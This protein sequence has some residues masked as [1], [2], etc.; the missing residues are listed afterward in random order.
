MSKSKP[1]VQLVTAGPE[2]CPLCAG[3]KVH[4]SA[5]DLY[6]EAHLCD[7]IRSCARCDG[8]ATVLH[9]DD[10]G[11][12]V[13]RPCEDCAG[14]REAVRLYNLAQIPARLV[15]ATLDSFVPRTIEQTAAQQH[16]REWVQGF[17]PGWNGVLLVG[18]PGAGKT[19][20]AAAML[21]HVVGRRTRGLLLRVGDMLAGFKARYDRND[22]SAAEWR[23]HLCTVPLLVL[24]ELATLRTDWERETVGGIIEGRYNAR[25]T[26]IGTSNLSPDEV[27][28]MFGE[29]GARIVSRLMEMC[30]L[31][32]VRGPDAR[33]EMA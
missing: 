22:M 19:H 25:K 3:R 12:E 15:H 23:A 27:P 9:T 11:Y 17:R 32:V 31:V 21:R 28:G 5:G 16:C 20:L 7:C 33:K 2:P 10:L 26:T 1:V 24:D 13:L 29:A 8:E 4:L 14:P 6:A 30:P 18:P